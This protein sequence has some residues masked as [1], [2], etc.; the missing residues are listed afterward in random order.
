MSD[1]TQA[2]PLAAPAWRA[3]ET[4][5]SH[6]RV[7]TCLAH[8]EPDR[9]PIDFWAVAE[10]SD[11]LRRHY[12][13]PDTEALLTHLG[14]DFR[15][16]RGPSYVGLDMKQHADGVSEDLWG[17]RRRTI[18]F[19]EGEKRGTYK[20]LALSPLADARSVREEL[21]NRNS[22]RSPD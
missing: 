15:V 3:R 16:V 2:S 21:S 4:M 9:V 13:L 11:R 10:I 7:M 6:A 17:V 1:S 19:G 5:G 8:R 18:T 12:G 22:V 20:E 14:V